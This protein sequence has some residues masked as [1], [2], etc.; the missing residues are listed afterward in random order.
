MSSKI[1]SLTSR[2]LS[3]SSMEGDITIN[4]P[5]RVIIERRNCQILKKKHNR[6]DAKIIQITTTDKKKHKYH[7]QLQNNKR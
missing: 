6:H 7:A 2:G 4:V 5:R 1:I 3:D